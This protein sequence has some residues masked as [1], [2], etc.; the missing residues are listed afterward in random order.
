MD[1]T[2][3]GANVNL[4]AR[5]GLVAAQG[6]QIIVSEAVYSQVSDRFK[7]DKLAPMQLKGIKE[8][9]PLFWPRQALAPRS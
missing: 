9:V 2:V 7:F 4:A 6:G 3:L 5:L 1:Y 8:P